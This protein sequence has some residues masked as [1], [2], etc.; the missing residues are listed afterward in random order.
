[1]NVLKFDKVRILVDFIDDRH[2]ARD[3]ENPRTVVTGVGTEPKR[4]G[5]RIGT[6][7]IF[8]TVIDTETLICKK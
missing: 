7:K 5:S 8:G 3:D 1:M 2:H 4:T 6:F